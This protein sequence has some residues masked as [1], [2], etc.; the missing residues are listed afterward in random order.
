MCKKC[1]LRFVKDCD[2][3]HSVVVTQ[4]MISSGYYRTSP[5]ASCHAAQPAQLCAR[6][7]TTNTESHEI[8]SYSLNMTPS[9][10]ACTGNSGA[11]TSLAEPQGC[12]QVHSNVWMP[13]LT[14]KVCLLEHSGH[15]W[16]W[17]HT[18]LQ[19][20]DA[21]RKATTRYMKHTQPGTP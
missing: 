7:G 12:A 11:C 3:G 19:S 21:L 13:V 20:R 4:L 10:G 14:G 5:T 8:S 9:E 17:R 1:G 15:L 6:L 2:G 16:Q 18:T